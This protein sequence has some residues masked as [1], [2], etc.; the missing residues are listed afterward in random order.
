MEKAFTHSM[1]VYLVKQQKENAF[2]SFPLIFQWN[3]FGNDG[4]LL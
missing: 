1:C 2:F 3:C 4:K